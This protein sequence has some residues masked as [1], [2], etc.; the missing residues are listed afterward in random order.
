MMT[1][2]RVS[3]LV[4]LAAPALLILGLWMLS[5]RMPSTSFIGSPPPLTQTEIAVRT[6]LK[7]H[8]HALAVDIGER[9]LRKPGSL[10]AASRWVEEVL[11]NTVGTP[12]REPVM[13]E[14][15]VAF[16]VYVDIPGDV[17]DEFI[18]IGAHYDS[19]PGSPGADDN[20]S[21]V[22]VLLE[23]ARLLRDYKPHVSLRF[24][25]FVNEESP[26]FG[27]QAM[28]S[29]KHV[30]HA[31]ARGETFRGMYSLEM[32]GYYSS[33]TNSQQYPS[34]LAF[35]YPTQGDFISFVGNLDSREFV[36]RSILAFRQAAHIPSEG[37]AAP[38]A[39]RDIGR[40]DH[41]SFWQDGTPALMVTDTANFR[42]PAYHTSSDTPASLDYDAMARVTMGLKAMLENVARIPEQR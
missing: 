16:N 32:L 20:A 40:S 3:A 9:H 15:E 29:F 18:V 11:T 24:I 25:A 13:T 31:K 14:V 30:E 19:V 22:A 17:E 23:L 4:L 26:W 6:R 28:G 2:R 33:E 27:T 42:N 21:G 37:I 5:V 34:P 8:V 41:R 10:A 39:L 7:Q 12:V 1:S 35:F 36:R 38:E